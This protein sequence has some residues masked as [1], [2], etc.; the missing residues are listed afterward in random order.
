MRGREE[1]LAPNR[2]GFIAVA[3]RTHHR[4][5]TMGAR[6]S[7]WCKPA[8]RVAAL[9][10]C[11]VQYITKPRRLYSMTDMHANSLAHGASGPRDTTP[12]GAPSR[13]SAALA[14]NSDGERHAVSGQLR[15]SNRLVLSRGYQRLPCVCSKLGLDDGGMEAHRSCL[16]QVTLPLCSLNRNHDRV[17][18]NSKRRKMGADG[19]GD[20]G[21]CQVRVVLL[22]HSRV[23]VPKLRGDD[24]HRHAAHGEC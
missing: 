8:Y 9:S 17:P 4:D 19:V 23:G 15:L 21:R 14:F 18:S 6:G 20:V 22:G 7:R 24:A 3:H 16:A 5:G 10:P 13:V 2:A 11:V 12:P 1:S